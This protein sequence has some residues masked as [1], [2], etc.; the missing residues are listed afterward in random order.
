MTDVAARWRMLA[1][2]F[3]VRTSMA[4]QFQLV[5]ALSPLVAGSLGIGLADIGL[6]IGLYLAPG[7]VIALPGGS[8]A[9]RFGDRRV[10]TAGI[11]LMT[12]GGTLAVVA[13][14]YSLQLAARVIAGTGGVIVNV[15]GSK[16]V[17]DWFAGREIATAMAI[18]VTSWPVGIALALIVLPSVAALGGL[19][20]ALAVP[21]AFAGACL[22]LALI[23]W[24]APP[25]ATVAASASAW[26][27]GR[28]LAMLG[29][30]AT[31]WALYNTAI[32]LVFGFSPALLTERGHSLIA[33]SAMTSIV[34]RLAA[35]TVP[36][37]G[38]IADRIGRRD[39]VLVT[40]LFGFA[41]GIV[42]VRA[43]LPPVAA[44]CLIGIAGGLPAGAILSFLAVILS[45]ATRAVGM[46]LFY[47]VFYLMTLIGPVLTGSIAARVSTA[48]V[49]F[50]FAVG[51]LALCLV[52]FAGLRRATARHVPGPVMPAPSGK[53]AP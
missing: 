32:I 22:V 24:H 19:V 48:A 3:T 42:A 44:F 30:A 52:L 17:V 1:L 33:A 28:R 36:L 5:G 21:A 27:R 35:V 11:V 2:L 45:P 31:I 49:S 26:P 7:I 23:A 4:F 39:L 29:A 10:F 43:G 40:G 34:L 14:S 15:A 9:S 6:L 50:D 12:L 8:L 51:C 41:A 47:T 53:T 38:I 25:A 46:G 37:G 16:L 18:Y 13:D 20:A